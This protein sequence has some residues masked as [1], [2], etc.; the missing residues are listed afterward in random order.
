VR[1][2]KYIANCGYTSRRRAEL[3][4]QAGRVRV[5]GSMVTEMGFS[6]NAGTDKVTINGDRI[7]PPERLT[8]MLHKLPGFISST[9]DTH[10][11]L[12]VMDL[13]PRRMRE[14]GVMPVGRLD[15]D[16]TG[17]L[18]LSNDG[19]LNHRITHPSYEIEKEYVA[20][21]EGAPRPEAIH[22][23]QSGIPI[24]GEMTAPAR[25]FDIQT[26][27]G[28]TR[29][30]VVISEGRK[31]QIKKMFDAVGHPVLSLARIR[32]GGLLLGK[33]HPGDWRKLHPGEVEA[34][35]GKKGA[36]KGK[37]PA[38]EQAADPEDDVPEGYEGPEED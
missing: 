15:L 5:N 8:I 38:S 33:L 31:R 24:E 1:L 12:T 3:L 25:V 27:A 14:I 26:Q 21:V 16:T 36:A 29:L 19:D 7:T 18:I 22:R 37:A 20:E 28:R 13:L 4:I 35:L 32:V 34:I 10:E 9:H 23:L 11:R 2:H 6:V 30:H 17:L